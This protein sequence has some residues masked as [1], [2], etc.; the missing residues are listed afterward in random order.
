MS[1][2]HALLSASGSHKWLHCTPS[3]RL[4]ETMPETTS[5]YA[6]EGRLAHAIAELKLRKHFTPLGPR[7]FTAEL[8]KLQES[9][10]YKEEMLEHTDAY[11]EYVQ[12]VCHAYDATPHVAIERRVDYSDYAPEGFGTSD[13]IVIGSGLLHVIDFKYGQGVLVPAEGNTQMMLYALGALKAYAM[14]YE[15]NRVCMTIV[16]PRHGA[17]PE[18][19]VTVDELRAWGESIK[20]VAQLAFEG[21]G[22]FCPGPWCKN[23]FCKVRETCRAR[24]E[25]YT[26]TVTALE[27]FGKAKPPLITNDEL[28]GILARAEPIAAW[29]KDLQD[30]ALAAILRGEEVAGWKAVEGRSNRQF[31]D[32]DKAFHTLTDAGYDEALLYERKPITLTAVEKLLGKTNFSELVADYVIKPPGKPTLV[33]ESDKREPVN[34]TQTAAEAFSA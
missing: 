22:D 14:L 13:C 32:V 8:K 26:G 6:E 29:V 30:Y 9:P 4:E 19:Q 27:A 1:A 7:K 28:G 16:Q 10:Y 25:L 17:A 34:L 3:A 24:A 21:K 2:G 18:Y 11:L 33:P 12:Q 5:G 23:G 20:P 31:S 15:I